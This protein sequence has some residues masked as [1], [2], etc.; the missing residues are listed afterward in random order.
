MKTGV[1]LALLTVAVTHAGFAYTGP[2]VTPEPTPII[3]PLPATMPQPIVAAPQRSSEPGM[4]TPEP[5]SG[6]ARIPDGRPCAE[7]PDKRAATKHALC[8]PPPQ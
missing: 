2:T 5:A 4:S 3:A 6:G 7:V 8:K 1:A